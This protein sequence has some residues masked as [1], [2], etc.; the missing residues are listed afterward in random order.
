VNEKRSHRITGTGPTDCL[1]Q[2]RKF[3]LIRSGNFDAVIDQE[4]CYFS[5]QD[6]AVQRCCR[7]VVLRVCDSIE[8]PTSMEITDPKDDPTATA[9]HSCILT[10]ETAQLLIDNG[11]K[12]S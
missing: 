5:G 7:G 12:V 3:T 8:A 11:V 9:L 10:G 6:A 2:W 4:L 1:V